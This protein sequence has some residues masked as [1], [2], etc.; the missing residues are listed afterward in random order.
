MH[1]RIVR[2]I[3]EVV[4]SGSIRAASEKLHVAP[5]AISR[6]IKALEEE[7][8]TPIF[9]RAARDLSLTSAGELLMVHIRETLRNE[10]KTLSQIEDLKG[11]R[12]G[13]LSLAIMSGLAG[14]VIPRSLI[15]FRR[16]NPRVELR[17]QVLPTDEAILD[18]VASGE[19]DFGVGFDFSE[20]FG[21]RVVS[22]SFAKIGAV[23]NANHPLA[24][25]TGLRLAECLDYPLILADKTMVIRPF[26]DR[27]I[28]PLRS[29]PQLLVETNSIE[30]M[31][32]MAIGS[33][34]IAFLT[35]FDMER[36]L[37]KGNLVHV[38]V[39][40]LLDNTQRLMVVRSERHTNALADVYFESFITM[41]AEEA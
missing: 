16:A 14:N 11:L 1:S 10:A 40:E 24:K 5:S 39:Q 12:R 19:A 4:R 41:L 31:R 26:L 2:Y 37:Y 33:E 28:E 22:T 17:V 27:V 29:A 9:N 36:E 18:S 3:N 34:G 13:S 7:I 15:A 35:R 38:P 8:G 23:M 25:R 32:A 21:L 6:Q 30:V 20:R